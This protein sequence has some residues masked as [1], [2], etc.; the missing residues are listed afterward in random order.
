MN[1]VRQSMQSSQTL[2]SARLRPF[3][4]RL[5]LRDTLQVLQR[6]AYLPG[7]GFIAVQVIGRLS[8]IPHLVWWSCLPLA[9]WLLGL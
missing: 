3:V 2:L 6:T 1:P 9:L 7:V 8:P 4:W 5:R